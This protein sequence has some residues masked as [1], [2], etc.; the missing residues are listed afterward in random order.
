MTLGQVPFRRRMASRDARGPPVGS[1]GP[2]AHHHAHPTG[3]TVESPLLPGGAA[4]DTFRPLVVFVVWNT[5]LFVRF[6]VGEGSFPLEATL[7]FLYIGASLMTRTDYLNIATVHFCLESTAIAL[8]SAALIDNLTIDTLLRGALMFDALQ[9]CGMNQFA[10]TAVPA[11]YLVNQLLSSPSPAAAHRFEHPVIAVGLYYAFGMCAAWAVDANRLLLPQRVA[12]HRFLR[13]RTA[14]VGDRLAQHRRLAACAR[15]VA[16]ALERPVTAVIESRVLLEVAAWWALML[17][18]W[19]EKISIGGLAISACLLVGFG[20][21]LAQ[22][23]HSGKPRYVYQALLVVA[24]WACQGPPL[25][26][27]RGRQRILCAALRRP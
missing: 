1:A 7:P 4:S 22:D 2:A 17:M 6:F 24:V 16:G 18:E 20:A 21:A 8:V 3:A 13:A 25:H 23:R 9:W 5:L 11:V 12:V 14:A 27:E 15:W 26:R 10:A 19:Y